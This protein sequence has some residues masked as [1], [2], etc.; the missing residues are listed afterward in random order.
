MKY[1]CVLGF[2][3]KIRTMRYSILTPTSL[4]N[5]RVEAMVPPFNL[6]N[7]A[8]CFQLSYLIHVFVRLGY[9]SLVYSGSLEHKMI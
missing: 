8:Q 5:F 7:I 6:A 9:F 4:A 2:G 3:I 1:I